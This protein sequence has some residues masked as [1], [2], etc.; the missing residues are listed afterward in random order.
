MRLKYTG[1]ILAIVIALFAAITSSFASNASTSSSKLVLG[2]YPVYHAYDDNAYRA[3]SSHFSYLNQ[4]ATITFQINSKGEVIGD[5]P[6]EGVSLAGPKQI[7]TYAAFTNLI[8]SGFD[9]A[10]AHQIL[11]NPSI[12]KATIQNIK[13]VAQ[14]SHYSGVSIDFEN[15]YASD[16]ANFNLF[17]QQLAS[18]LRPLKIQTAVCV[19]SKTADFASSPWVG[20]FD[21]RTLGQAADQ[22]HLMTYDQN[23][24][25][26]EPGPVAGLNWMERILAYA[27]SQIPAS[28]LMIG[29]PAY[30]YD[31]N[32]AT[33]QGNEA[34][35]W[36]A[37]PQLIQSTKSVPKWDEPSK[38]P[39]FTYTGQDGSKHIV[40]YE[41]SRS[42]QLKSALVVKYKLAGVF[43]W[44]LGLEDE[45]FWKALSS[46]LGKNTN[47]DGQD[48]STTPEKQPNELIVQISPIQPVYH[49]KESL[50]LTLHVVDSQ[51]NP[52][53]GTKVTITITRPDGKFTRY[54]GVTDKSGNRK[55]RYYHSQAY[56]LGTYQVIVTVTMDGFPDQQ[57]EF[58]Y[59]LK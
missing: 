58:T 42:I 39:Y 15:M 49:P 55:I 20:V 28:K 36:K 53:K 51:N 4:V 24:P 12:R 16:R 57:S 1:M 46:G 3:L 48:P 52:L 19:M 44:R 59:Q 45:N 34:V 2:Y 30:G 56:P 35:A 43:M 7:A 11:S 17:I 23:G 29:V 13:K 6:Q 9:S 27:T 5:V 54:S 10:L 50:P 47:S 21:Y 38:S 25:W 31:W 8:D 32:V 26:G 33:K 40:W 22:I 37:I 14:E 18:T 41:D